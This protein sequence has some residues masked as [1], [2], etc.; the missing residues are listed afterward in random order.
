M[1]DNEEQIQKVLFGH[2]G[3][4]EVVIITPIKSAFDKCVKSLCVEES[5]KDCF[6]EN[7]KFE[8]VKGRKGI[9]IYSPQGIAS[10]DC[11]C[12][13]RN[14]EI[15]FFGYAGSLADD[16][17]VGT[18]IEV[19]TVIDNETGNIVEGLHC[20]RSDYTRAVCGYSPC[21]LGELADQYGEKARSKNGTIIDMETAY[22]ATVALK[23]LCKF[24]SWVVVSDIPNTVNFWELSEDEMKLFKQAKNEVIN[25]I[26]EYA[27]TL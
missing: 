3:N 19:D 10:Q 23:N 27:K 6:F 8:T 2:V 12:L 11:I 4:Y 13:F 21:M 15:I 16:I 5:F 22:C 20:L 18:K 9:I 26:I 1:A 25:D 24:T 17:V 7:A 14:A